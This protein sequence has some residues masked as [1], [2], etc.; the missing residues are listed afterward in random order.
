MN[1]NRFYIIIIIGLLIFNGIFVF[2]ITQKGP[3][4]GLR[5]SPKEIISKRL[6]FREDQNA[7]YEELI[8]MH[9]SKT[10]ELTNAIKESRNALYNTMS[11]N[12][13]MQLH[14]SIINNITNSQAE[15]ELLNISHFQDIKSLCEPSQLDD[16]N[17]LSRD[18]AK[19]FDKHG[20]HPHL[21]K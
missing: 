21:K 4:K 9:R 12:G 8:H 11:I 13:S 2:F 3:R 5:K 10:V 20:E 17:A 1:K 19:L 18:L 7:Q 6:N 16:F 14:D 15:L